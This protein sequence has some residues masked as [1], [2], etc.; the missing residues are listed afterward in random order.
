MLVPPMTY[1]Q[2]HQGLCGQGSDMAGAIAAV[3]PGDGTIRREE[4]RGKVLW[5]TTHDG[6][7]GSD[8]HLVDVVG[9]IGLA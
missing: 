9:P 5:S 1:F 2:G 8:V 7:F 3:E 6:H 4:A